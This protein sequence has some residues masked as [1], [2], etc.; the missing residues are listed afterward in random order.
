MQ[1]TRRGFVGAIV[2]GLMFA[3]AMPAVAQEYP[4]AK[5]V[6]FFSAFPPGGVLTAIFDKLAAGIKK[7]IGG[8]LILDY[9]PG[10][11]TTI[12]AIH[13]ANAPADGY[14]FLITTKSTHLKSFDDGAQYKATDLVPVGNMVELAE[15]MF[16]GGHVGAKTLP[17]LIEHFKAKPGAVPVATGAPGTYTGTLAAAVE[18]ELGVTFNKV[19]YAGSQLFRDAIVAGTADVALGGTLPGTEDFVKNGQIIPVAVFAGERLPGAP[20]LPTFKELGYPGLVEENFYGIYAPAGTPRPVL[21]KMNAAISKVLASPEYAEEMVKLGFW[22]MPRTLDELAAV[23][24][25]DDAKLRAWL[26]K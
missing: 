11:A 1:S 5:P 23:Q 17:E 22:V 18:K 8:E 10:G 6:T 13:V 15:T 2:A 26:G 14:T 20:D 25:A 3:A 12:A 16:I 9:K 7:E 4:L 19:P 21:E 24:A